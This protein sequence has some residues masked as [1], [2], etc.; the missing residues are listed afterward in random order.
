[1]NL[2]V[3]KDLNTHVFVAV[4]TVVDVGLLIVMAW[5]MH[6][7]KHTPV[8]MAKGVCF[9]EIH[10]GISVVW[11]ILANLRGLHLTEGWCRWPLDL[12][13]YGVLQS[14]WVGVWILRNFAIEGALYG[15]VPKPRHLLAIA[16]AL[17]SFPVVGGVVAAL[18]AG[19]TSTRASDVAIAITSASHLCVMQGGIIWLRRLPAPVRI[20]PEAEWCCFV[21]LTCMMAVSLLIGTELE[22]EGRY[23]F[24]PLTVIWVTFSWQ[25]VQCK[26]VLCASDASYDPVMQQPMEG[27]VG[28][29]RSKSDTTLSFLQYCRHSHPQTVAMVEE[30]SKQLLVRMVSATNILDYPSRDTE[31]NKQDGCNRVRFFDELLESGGHNSS[32]VGNEIAVTDETRARDCYFHREFA[33]NSLRTALAATYERECAE[34]VDV[35]QRIV[36]PVVCHPALVGLG[37]ASR[38]PA[39]LTYS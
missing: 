20:S 4:L 8:V 25:Y 15:R 18:T 31:N 19:C 27:G 34:R 13:Q 14:A 28:H 22:Y 33:Y 12:L 10:T 36:S 30:L 37:F 21:A 5:R 3:V 2:A 24:A 16:V 29:Y 17:L 38:R 11:V 6:Q 32:F 7:L 1:M 9:V 26:P 35:M 23:I 39:T